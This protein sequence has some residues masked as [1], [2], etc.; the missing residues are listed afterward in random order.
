M[1]LERKSELRNSRDESSENL[2]S[3]LEGNLQTRIDE[4]SLVIGKKIGARDDGLPSEE[5]Y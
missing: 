2:D 5:C 1:K 4:I 3:K